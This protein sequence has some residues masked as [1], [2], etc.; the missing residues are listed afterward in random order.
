MQVDL[1]TFF[2]VSHIFI[3]FVD[4]A[5]LAGGSQAGAQSTCEM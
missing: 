1:C 3:V 4:S 2:H 5:Q